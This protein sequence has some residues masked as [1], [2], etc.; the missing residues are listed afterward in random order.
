MSIEFTDSTYYLTI[1]EMATVTDRRVQNGGLEFRMP[2]LIV[3]IVILKTILL[4]S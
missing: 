3:S 4:K 1:V 2:G